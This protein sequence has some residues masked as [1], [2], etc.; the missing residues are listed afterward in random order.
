MSDI[1]DTRVAALEAAQAHFDDEGLEEYREEI[2]TLLAMFRA[3][4]GD[5]LEVART[6][7]LLDAACQNCGFSWPAMAMRA[8]VQDSAIA[9]QRLGMCPRCFATQNIVLKG[10]S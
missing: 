6:R 1:I 10:Q 4:K 9:A 2:E 7:T 5:A 8:P 3:R